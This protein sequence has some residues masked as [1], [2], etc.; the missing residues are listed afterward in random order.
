MVGGML[1]DHQARRDDQWPI[2]GDIPLLG[3]LFTMDSFSGKKHNLLISVTSR[4]IGGDGSPIRPN[5]TP[6]VPDF[7]R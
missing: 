7:R 6:G 2:L 3:R 5:P 4:L 1:V